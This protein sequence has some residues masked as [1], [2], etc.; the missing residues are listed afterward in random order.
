MRSSRFGQST[1]SMRT[2]SFLCGVLALCG[3]LGLDRVLALCGLLDFC[4]EY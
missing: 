4:A 1:S 2:A 3:V